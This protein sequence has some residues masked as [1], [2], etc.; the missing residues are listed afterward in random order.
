MDSVAYLGMGI[1]GRGMAANLLDAGYDLTV[2]NRTAEKCQPLVDQGATQADTPADAARNADAVLYCLADD[3]AVEAVVTGPDGLLSVA[4]EGQ[5]FVDMSTV[6]PSTST[7]QAEAYAQR[8]A[9]FLSAP[10]FGSKDEA[11]EG[12][13]WIVAGGLPETFERV[14]PVLEPLSASIHHMGA[15]VRAGTSMKLVGNLLVAAML[16]GL[17]EALVLARKSDL[18]LDQVLD[19]LGEVDFRSPLYDGMGPSMATHDFST[20]FALK[21]MLKD[22]NLIA[23]LAEDLNVPV[24]G[25]TTTRERL[26][27]AVNQGWGEENAS[28]LV[29][30]LE[31]DAATSLDGSDG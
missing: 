18:D 24:P 22:A 21:H 25:H 1:M 3:D 7:T 16:E 23:R 9:G 31:Q 28:A 6:H 15:D 29:K 14:R 4:D 27:A 13:L 26:K 17:A 20:F 30:I 11:A 12:H 5:V 8:G 2:W 10:V 19:V